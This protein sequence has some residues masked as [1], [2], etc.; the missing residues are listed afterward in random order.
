[1]TEIRPIPSAV[2]ATNAEADADSIAKP[3]TASKMCVIKE[4]RSIMKKYRIRE[5]SIADFGRYALTGLVFFVGLA[6][7]AGLTY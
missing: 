4:G 1:M 3:V 5:G 7:F 2:S 6:L